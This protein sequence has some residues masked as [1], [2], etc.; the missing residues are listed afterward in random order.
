LST[1][2]RLTA[3]ELVAGSLRVA[4][5]ER[6]AAFDSWI[7]PVY[8]VAFALLANSIFMNEFFLAGVVDMAPYFERLPLLFA[9]LLP[10]VSMRLWAEERRARTAELL[11]TLPLQPAQAIIGK[12][13]AA[14]G[15]LVL[16]LALVLAVSVPGDVALLPGVGLGP[17]LLLGLYLGAVYL[18]WQQQNRVSWQPAEVA[19]DHGAV[20]DNG[21]LEALPMAALVGRS[22]LAALVILLAGVVLVWTSEA[23]ATKSGLGTS[24]IGVTL[25]ASATSLP[26]LSTTLAAV[27][28]G[29]HS[30]AVADV[31]GSNL[32]MV[33]LLFPS[34]LLYRDGLLLDAIDPS[35]RFALTLGIIVTSIYLAGLVLRQRHRVLG[36]GLDS[37]AVLVCYLGGL[38]V[39]Y[40]L[41]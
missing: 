17:L 26:E 20:A 8:A 27:R 12:H 33:A 32:I 31:L 4:G 28:L 39:L 14:L 22:L 18:L 9:A 34:D 38:A 7:A 40:H 30:M 10:A 35:A 19:D 3:S 11:L 37:W 13:L 15:I 2:A 25:L 36:L 21:A 29:R 23:V 24:F 1:R 6:G 41:R 5:R 16:F